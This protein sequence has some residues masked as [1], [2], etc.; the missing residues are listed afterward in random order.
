M[1]I[2]TDLKA[3]LL[4]GVSFHAFN[5]LSGCSF[6]NH[7]TGETVSIQITA[8][9]LLEYYFSLSS[10]LLSNKEIYSFLER[11]IHSEFI[12]TPFDAIN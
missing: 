3:I 10:K 12:S 11:L 5:D 6:Y 7:N 1:Q 2:L 9:Q 4:E 8:E